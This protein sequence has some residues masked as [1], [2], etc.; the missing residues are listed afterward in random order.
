M[1]PSVAEHLINPVCPWNKL[2]RRVAEHV[3]VLKVYVPFWLAN[4]VGGRP[5]PDPPESAQRALCFAE[6]GLH[7]HA[8]SVHI[9]GISKSCLRIVRILL[10]SVL[11]A[12]V[13]DLVRAARFSNSFWIIS[14]VLSVDSLCLCN[15]H[16]G[17]LANPRL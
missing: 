14:G 2:G 1:I 12:D 13:R 6:L 11:S 16:V 8:V 5:S 9:A 15:A 4:F 3:Y 10:R 7:L 17:T